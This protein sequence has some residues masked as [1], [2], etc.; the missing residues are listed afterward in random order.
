M[1][2][3]GQLSACLFPGMVEGPS[4]VI[5]RITSFCP[6]WLPNFPEKQRRRL[7]TMAIE[8]DL[9]SCASSRDFM[10]RF[11]LPL[12]VADTGYWTRM[13]QAAQHAT[14][15]CLLDSRTDGWRCAHDRVSEVIFARRNPIAR[16]DGDGVG[17]CEDG[18]CSG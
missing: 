15:S 5:R 4:H 2:C 6:I 17:E 7:Y 14:V 12:W 8:V 9:T 11:P 1:T 18:P 13:F 10:H 16:I 3:P